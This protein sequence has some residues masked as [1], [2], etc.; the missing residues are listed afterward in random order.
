MF[1]RF[2]SRPSA[3]ATPA[4]PSKNELKKAAKKAEK[5]KLAAEKAAKA[6]AREEALAATEPV[7]VSLCGSC[8]RWLNATYLRSIA[9]LWH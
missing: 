9:G 5:E 3:D 1:P 4:G 6:K 8:T 7:S 2:V